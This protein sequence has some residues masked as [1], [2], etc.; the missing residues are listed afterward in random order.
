MAPASSAIHMAAGINGLAGKIDTQVDLS[1]TIKGEDVFSS[2]QLA[3]PVLDVSGSAMMMAHISQF[4]LPAH[5]LVFGFSDV[6]F[7]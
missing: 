1:L 6:F 7:G 5:C 4:E 2:L 3:F